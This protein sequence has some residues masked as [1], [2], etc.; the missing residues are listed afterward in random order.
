[1]KTDIKI[2][3]PDPVTGGHWRSLAVTGLP[4]AS[5]WATCAT[6]CA[7][8][9]FPIRLLAACSLFG[10]GSHSGTPCSRAI[11]LGRVMRTRSWSSY[12]RMGVQQVSVGAAPRLW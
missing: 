1:M 10:T 3:A 5:R 6:T 11:S 2:T 8:T 4:K 9:A 7:A 12:T